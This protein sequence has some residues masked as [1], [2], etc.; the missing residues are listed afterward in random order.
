MK[1]VEYF[2]ESWMTAK[3]SPTPISEEKKTSRSHK[4]HEYEDIWLYEWDKSIASIE[5]N[6]AC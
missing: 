6:E 2:S 1:R 4:R 3:E 5:D